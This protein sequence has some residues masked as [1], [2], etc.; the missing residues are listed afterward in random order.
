M[1]KQDILY[2]IICMASI[3]LIE[4]IKANNG[5]KLNSVL[6]NQ[7]LKINLFKYW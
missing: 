2:G 4:K 3:F 7:M 1:L 6:E 5:K